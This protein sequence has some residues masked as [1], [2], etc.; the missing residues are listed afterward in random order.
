M[1]D[2]EPLDYMEQHDDAPQTITESE[3]GVTGPGPEAELTAVSRPLLQRRTVRIMLMLA[4]VV[5]V[6]VV[7]GVVAYLL[8][9]SSRGEPIDVGVYPG[10]TLVAEEVIY[11]GYDHYQYLSTDPVIEIEAFFDDQDDMD[12]ER[13]YDYNQDPAEHLFTTCL[14]DR[15]A[16]DMTQFTKVIIQP[17]RDDENALTGQ[18]LIDVQRQWES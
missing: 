17:V 16:S 8:F 11:D 6:V 9:R 12:C 18:V 2:Q 13:Q 1:S 4:I 7:V 5:T 15:S 14:I 10:S 3:P